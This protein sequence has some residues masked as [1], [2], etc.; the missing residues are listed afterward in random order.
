MKSTVLTSAVALVVLAACSPKPVPA[1]AAN[2]TSASVVPVVVH[3]LDCEHPMSGRMP[4]SQVLKAYGPDAVEGQVEGWSGPTQGIVLYSGSKNERIEL[5]W[6]DRRQT[7]AMAARAH[8]DGTAWI[9]PG[10]IHVGSTLA[11]VEAAN[12]KPLTLSDLGQAEGP[13]A[14][15]KGGRMTLAGGCDLGLR[16]GVTDAGSLPA[17]I[18]GKGVDVVSDDARLKPYNIV[19]VEMAAGWRPPVPPRPAQIE[20]RSVPLPV[21]PSPVQNPETETPK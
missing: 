5:I 17:D 10:G 11:E 18:G 16:F 9:G 12:G 3:T 4:A 15:L 13:Y 21:T 6:W 20:M 1:P 8:G 14:D 2:G 7:Q 19:V